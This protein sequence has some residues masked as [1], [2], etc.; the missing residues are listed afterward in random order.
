MK[1]IKFLKDSMKMIDKVEMDL[2][3]LSTLKAN[4]A[5]VEKL[6]EKLFYQTPTLKQYE[7][8]KK[9]TETQIDAIKDT[10]KAF[11]KKTDRFRID[12]GRLNE[13]NEAKFKDFDDAIE[14]TEDKVTSFAKDI[15][16][17]TEEIEQIF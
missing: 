12:Q 11:Q 9:Y 6:Q 8:L 5:T 2:K 13:K 17:K 4:V 16:K 10:S 7:E 14:M 1:E 3:K 15:E